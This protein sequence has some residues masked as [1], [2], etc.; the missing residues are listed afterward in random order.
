DFWAIFLGSS[1]CSSI[2]SALRAVPAG[3][4]FAERSIK[5]RQRKP[6]QARSFTRREVGQILRFL[7]KPDNFFFQSM[8]NT[9]SPL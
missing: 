2:R 3:N 8:Q 5:V 7:G 9:R 1:I 4:K 6:T